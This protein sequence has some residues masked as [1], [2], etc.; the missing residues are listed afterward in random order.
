MNKK[1]ASLRGDNLVVPKA[2]A[3]AAKLEARLG[4]LRRWHQ[5]AETSV[6]KGLLGHKPQLASALLG[7]GFTSKANRS[8]SFPFCSLGA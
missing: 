7:K 8:T 6:G 4:Q 2:A 3:Q 5:R 1:Y